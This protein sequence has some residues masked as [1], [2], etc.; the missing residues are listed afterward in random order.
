MLLLKGNVTASISKQ[1]L[2]RDMGSGIPVEQSLEA[3][4]LLPVVFK[5]DNLALNPLKGQNF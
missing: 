4:L 3:F 1:H 5:N 2:I